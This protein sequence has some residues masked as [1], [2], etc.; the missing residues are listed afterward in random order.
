MTQL[1]KNIQKAMVAAM[2]ESKIDKE[3]KISEIFVQKFT[4]SLLLDCANLCMAD[5]KHQGNYGAG[6]RLSKEMQKHFG[7][8]LDDRE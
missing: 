6:F 7:V 1:N 8:S 4:E 3:S 5:Y 2:K